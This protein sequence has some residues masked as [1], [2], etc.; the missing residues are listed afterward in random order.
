MDNGLA[1][2]HDAS[3]PP[4]PRPP[5]GDQP[6]VA[7]GGDE[8]EEVIVQHQ[9]VR[10]TAV[11]G[12]ADPKWGETPVAAVVLRFIEG[13]E[14]AEVAAALDVSVPTARRDRKSVV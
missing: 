13:M 2:D 12:V 7:D 10:E 6:A 4:A 3:A 5:A 8:I 1:P 9:A 11:F 14:A